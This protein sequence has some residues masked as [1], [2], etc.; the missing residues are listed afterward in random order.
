MHGTTTRRIARRVQAVCRHTSRLTEWRSAADR[1]ILKRARR[2]PRGFC[3][4]AQCAHTCADAPAIT[5]LWFSSVF[6]RDQIPA[7]VPLPSPTS[8]AQLNTVQCVPLALPINRS[9][10]VFLLDKGIKSYPPPPPLLRPQAPSSGTSTTASTSRSNER[11]TRPS[12][13]SD[14]SSAP[15]YLFALLTML[16]KLTPETGS[17]RATSPTS[18][19]SVSAAM[20][21]TSERRRRRILHS[22]SEEDAP[23]SVRV[24]GFHLHVFPPRH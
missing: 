15:C 17:I 16:Q 23:T 13:I 8:H 24:S 2:P 20:A 14:F 6:P 5:Y 18:I 19:T 11:E 1:S 12:P 10:L 7:I 9:S 4:H 3:W 21:L 22:D